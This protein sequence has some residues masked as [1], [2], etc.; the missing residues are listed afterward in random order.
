MTKPIILLASGTGFA[1]IKAIVEHMIHT[2]NVRR[3]VLYWGG[4]RPSDFVSG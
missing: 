4:R 2:G 1:P 3:F